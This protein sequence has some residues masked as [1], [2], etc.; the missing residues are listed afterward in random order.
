[1]NSAVAEFEMVI[2][3]TQPMSGPERLP[4]SPRPTVHEGMAPPK[5]TGD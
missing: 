3:I 1:L 5:Q 4:M 2:C